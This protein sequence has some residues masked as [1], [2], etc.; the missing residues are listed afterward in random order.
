M[1]HALILPLLIGALS[2]N[3]LAEEIGSVSTKFKWMGP[4]D[5]I[6]VE[7]FQDEDIPGV[8]CYLSRAKTGG[9]S[10]AVGV[11]ED[12]SDAAIECTQIGPIALPDDVRSGK[13][14]GEQVFKK[15]T[16]LLFKSLQVV[17]FYDGPRNALVYLTYSDRIIEGS[18]KNS[19]SAV[20]I[21]PWKTDPVQ[22]AV[23]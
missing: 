8:V 5:K 7:V 14:N 12:T 1:R 2:G 17:R 3:A 10:G 9:V 16:S 23:K 22:P 11:A 20:A 18:P 19:V 6:V 4:N 21:Q 15:R 13:R